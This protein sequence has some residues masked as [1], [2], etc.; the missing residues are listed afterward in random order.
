MG[1]KV[2]VS[3]IKAMQG[4][5]LGGFFRTLLNAWTRLHSPTMQLQAQNQTARV[6]I[7]L[8]PPPAS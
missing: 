2:W 5:C 4:N 1:K 3:F 6:L 7:L 8:L